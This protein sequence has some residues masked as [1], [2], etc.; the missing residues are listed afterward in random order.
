MKPKDRLS[1]FEAW[2]KL[3]CGEIISA[4]RISDRAACHLR[5][6]AVEIGREFID[7]GIGA[8]RTFRIC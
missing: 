4:N 6:H 5:R 2:Q 7:S 8:Y 3:L 1:M